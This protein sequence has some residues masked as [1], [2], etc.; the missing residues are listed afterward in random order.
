MNWLAHIFLSEYNIDFQIGNYLA[1]PL[2]TKA[3]EGASSD[4]KNGIKTHMIIDSY[5][6]SHLIVKKSK[7]RL[8]ENGLLKSIV[9]DITYDYILTKNWDKFCNISFE[10]FTD[11]FYTKAKK[12]VKDLPKHAQEPVNK[13]LKFKILNKYQNLTDLEIAF[14]RF[15]NRLSQRLLSRDSASS[16][17]KAVE[18]NIDF[19]QRDFLDFFPQLCNKIKPLIEEKNIH[20][21]KI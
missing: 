10:E 16:Y 17:F 1:D 3:W 19:L 13:M 20:H 12:R 8:R 18:S 5:T 14:N 9:V 4:L 2:K 6:D 15:D 7:H 21:W 11:T